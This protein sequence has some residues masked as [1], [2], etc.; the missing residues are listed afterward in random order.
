VDDLTAQRAGVDEVTVLL[1]YLYTVA[2]ET[3]QPTMMAVLKTVVGS[4][5]TKELMQTWVEEQLERGRQQGEVTGR[6]GSLLRLLAG[7][8]IHVDDQSRQRIM[9]CTDI[10][11]LDQW[12]DRAV[13][14]TQL[15]E[16]FGDLTQ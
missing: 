7:R 10:A 5:R 1:Q 14:A 8:R 6:A 3:V 2:S 9:S 4:Q 13:N 16:V 11:T 12:F 15:S